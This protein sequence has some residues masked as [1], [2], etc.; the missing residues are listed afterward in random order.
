MTVLEIMAQVKEG[1]L[2]EEQG[3]KMIEEASAEQV[4]AATKKKLT[5]KVSQKGAVQLDGLRR[6]P[7]TLYRDE[8]EQVLEIAPEI[9]AFIAVNKSKLAEKGE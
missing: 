2:T 4:K 5:L 9:K 8:W 7:V 1:K 6:F 3:A